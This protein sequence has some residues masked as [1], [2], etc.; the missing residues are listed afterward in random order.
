MDQ[1]GKMKTILDKSKYLS[2]LAIVV[3]LITFALALFW[4]GV[5][6]FKS[7]Q[8]IIQSIGQSPKIIL[9]ILKLIDILLVAMV[10]YI[11]AASI[12][13]LLF[14][15]MEMTSKLF[16]ISLSELKVKLS[17]LIVLVMAVHFVEV[18]FDEGITGLEKL[19]QAIA[20]FLIA[21]VLILFGYLSNTHG[22]QEHKE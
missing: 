14:T 7:W 18:I 2:L 3:L 20:I 15:K 13:E 10:L 11:L 8:L 4:G 9:S 5:Q 22:Q 6:A 12:H 17:N 16:S 19:W 21:I 1:K